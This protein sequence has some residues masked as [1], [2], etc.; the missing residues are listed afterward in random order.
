MALA[1]SGKSF[2][3]E[4]KRYFGCLPGQTIQG[5][6]AEMKALS[7][8]EKLWFHAELIGQGIQCDPPL[9]PAV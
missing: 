9:A 1:T 6:A 8:E 7:Y 2:M 5:F 4:M 3:G